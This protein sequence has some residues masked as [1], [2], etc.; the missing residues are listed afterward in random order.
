MRHLK[1]YHAIRMIRRHGSIRKAADLLSVSPSALNRSIQGFE[2]SLGVRIFDRVP[3]GVRLTSAGELL[4][5]VVE[6]HLVEFE[7]LQRQLGFLRD[8][9]MGQLRI[10]IG[11]DIAAGLPLFAIRDLEEEMPGVSA[12]IV[13]GDIVNLLLRRELDLAILTNPETDR[14]V[15]VLA[16]Q[17]VPLVA[18]ATPGWASRVGIDAAAN[19]GARVGLWDMVRTRI[20]VPP[21]GTGSRAVISH[22]LRRHALEEGATTSVAASQLPLAMATGARSCIFPATVFAGADDIDTAAGLVPLAVDVG[23]VQ[24]SV[25]RHGGIPLTRPGQILLRQVERRLNALA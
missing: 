3:A 8:G 21:E 20:V 1:I 17:S 15:E 25:L 11:A 19:G 24:V 23:T 16:S 12:D 4:V 9:H 10:G 6:R 13:T 14:A 18:L 5:D 2:E 7:D 22:A